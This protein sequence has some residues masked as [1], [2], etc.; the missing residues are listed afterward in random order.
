MIVPP[1]EQ[2]LFDEAACAVWGKDKVGEYSQA[3][4][5]DHHQDASSSFFNRTLYFQQLAQNLISETGVSR[6]STDPL[7]TEG[8]RL[9][10]T[11]GQSAPGGSDP[12]EGGARD[13]FSKEH[14]IHQ[15]RHEDLRGQKPPI[16][17][18]NWTDASA[19]V[20]MLMSTSIF[21]FVFAFLLRKLTAFEEGLQLADLNA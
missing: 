8:S 16:Y 5:L 9:Q 13:P 7:S 6:L 18:A 12:T 14:V 2:L 1:E 10:V 4:G 20:I 17:L 19:H 21:G 11:R 15:Q 3:P